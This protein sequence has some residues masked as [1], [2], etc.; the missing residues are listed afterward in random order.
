MSFTDPQSITVNA[1]AKTMPRISSEGTRSVYQKAEEDFKM[2]ISHQTSRD[3]TRRMVRVDQ[4]VVAVNPLDATSEYKSLGVYLV[5]DE[6][7]YGFSDT[8]IDY[9]VQALK[10]WASSA[11][12]L[13]VCGN[14]H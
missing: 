7:E 4:R 14:E 3:R 11:N 12:V 1:V 9:L 5:I 13:K 10:T 6:P 2:T 8:D